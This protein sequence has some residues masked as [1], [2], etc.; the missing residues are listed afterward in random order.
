MRARGRGRRRDPILR[1]GTARSTRGVGRVTTWILLRAA[2]TGA[3]SCCSS[4]SRGLVATTAVV[5]KRVSKPTANLFRAFVASTGLALLGVH[6]GLLLVDGFMPFSVSA[7]TLPMAAEYRPLAVSAGVIA[8]YGLVA[9]LVT[10]WPAR[11]WARRGGDA[12]T[13]WP[14]RCSRSPS[15]TACSPAP[16]PSDRGCSS[17]MRSRDSS[18]CSSRSCE[19]SRT[20]T[21]LRV[22]AT[23]AIPG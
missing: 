21:G 5:T 12:C 14:C 16:T 18:W 20:G 2:G 15:R 13:S 23:R 1:G 11:A 7:I 17:S 10:S 4:R 3:T 19:P 8:M 6:L 22:D 9:V